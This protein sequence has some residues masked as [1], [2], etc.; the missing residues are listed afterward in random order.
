MINQRYVI[1]LPSDQEIHQL[2]RDLGYT[3]VI[4]KPK[5]TPLP[6]RASPLKQYTGIPFFSPHTSEETLKMLSSTKR[7]PPFILEVDPATSVSVLTKP[8]LKIARQAR[9]IPIPV[10]ID[11]H[12]FLNEQQN[13]KRDPLINRSHALYL[14]K[15]TIRLLEANHVPLLFHTNVTLEAVWRLRSP[16]LMMTLVGMIGVSQKSAI[17]AISKVPAEII[18]VWKATS[19]AEEEE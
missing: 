6:E 16:D 19:P 13:R 17:A 9:P 12:R 5:E 8:I 1:G 3:A 14:M 11:V 10:L 2:A 7:G 15:Q 18:R 4:L